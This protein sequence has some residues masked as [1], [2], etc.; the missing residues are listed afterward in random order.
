[1]CTPTVDGKAMSLERAKSEGAREEF[2]ESAQKTDSEANTGTDSEKRFSAD[3]G[4][5]GRC[6]VTIWPQRQRM[7]CE[8]ERCHSQ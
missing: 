2:R 4:I 5:T 3:L 7:Q 1:M 8:Q 6:T